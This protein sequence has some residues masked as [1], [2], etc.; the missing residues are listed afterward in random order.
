MRN[1]RSC[2]LPTPTKN[3][4]Y[5][6]YAQ[7]SS[8]HLSRNTIGTNFTGAL[9]PNHRSQAVC[10]SDIL[11]DPYILDLSF[12]YSSYC[13]RPNSGHIEAGKAVEVQ[14]WSIVDFAQISWN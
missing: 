6:R 8:G 11:R 1:A 12:D 14:G 2:A 13:V 9:G 5:S 10:P 7:S 3:L 4:W